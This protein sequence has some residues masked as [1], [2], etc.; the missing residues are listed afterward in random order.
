MR[1]TSPRW[2]RAV[3]LLILLVTVAYVSSGRRVTD[4]GVGADGPTDGTDAPEMEVELERVTVGDD[5]SVTGAG[6]DPTLIADV[7]EL[8]EGA[9]ELVDAAEDEFIRE[10]IETATG[11]AIEVPDVED[12]LARRVRESNVSETAIDELDAL[13]GLFGFGRRRRR[14]R[15]RE[16][17]DEDGSADDTT[18]DE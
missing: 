17:T 2:R 13:G 15:D 7:L 14:R 10:P 16:S 3:E 18:G 5:L 4:T 8:N 11:G 1:T 9:A 12:E 6:L